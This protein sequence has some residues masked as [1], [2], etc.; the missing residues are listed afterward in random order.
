MDN[1]HLLMPFQND[2]WKSPSQP[3]LLQNAPTD[4]RYCFISSEN[5]IDSLEKKLKQLKGKT[6][7][8]STSKEMVDSLGRV[9]DDQMQ[10]FLN[11]DSCDRLMDF[12]VDITDPSA[13]AFLQRRLH[14]ERQAV[15]SEELVYL[16]QDDALSK[17]VTENSENIEECSDDSITLSK[18]DLQVSTNQ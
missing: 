11:T 7:K 13:A 12:S 10:S 5:Y 4:P 16:L 17:T 2:P 1:Q 15:N 18:T 14:P 9:R 8:E 3:V 6:A